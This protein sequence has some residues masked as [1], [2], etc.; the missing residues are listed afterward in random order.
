MKGSR[1]LFVNLGKYIKLKV[2]KSHKSKCR[3]RSFETD[4]YFAQNSNSTYVPNFLILYFLENTEL[5]FTE[6][7]Y[8]ALFLTRK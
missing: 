1:L 8:Y 7:I 2:N 5:N 4:I 3:Q 6:N